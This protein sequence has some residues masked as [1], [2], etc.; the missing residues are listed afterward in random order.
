[1]IYEYKK[2]MKEIQEFSQNTKTTKADMLR[3][4]ETVKEVVKEMSIFAKKDQL[5][6][7]EKY[8][9]LLNIM[10]FV[11]EEELNKK[12]ETFKSNAKNPK[13]ETKTKTI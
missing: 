9:D 3:T 2:I 7:L 5:K 11:T 6:V 8:I 13:I 4:Q 12:L 1:M 10:D